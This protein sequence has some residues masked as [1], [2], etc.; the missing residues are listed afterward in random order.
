MRRFLLT[1]TTLVAVPLLWA[2]A[3]HA[4]LISIGL[5]EA[6]VNGGVV[7]TVA[8]DSGTGAASISDS[9][10]TFTNSISAIGSPVLTE[11]QLDSASINVSTAVAGE[12]TVYVTETG[13]TTPTGINKFLS[14]FTS[15]LFSGAVTSVI[16]ETLLSTTNQLYLGTALAA[17]KFTTS[18]QTAYATTTTAPLT[19]YSETEKYFITFAGSGDVNDTIDLKQAVP[20]PASLAIMGAGLIG[21][22]MIRR[23]KSA[24]KA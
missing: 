18:N 2:S 1:A 4:T 21:L 24:P 16:E 5:Q 10:G 22:S 17:T 8:T 20:E 15:N 12:I 11:P 14:S 9:Y 23:R 3:A 19:L 13:L 6:G 7:T